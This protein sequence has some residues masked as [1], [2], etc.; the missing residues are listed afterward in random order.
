M[1]PDRGAGPGGVADPIY[2]P[3]THI[4]MGSHSNRLQVAVEVGLGVVAGEEIVE[5]R[6][7]CLQ[8]VQLV[9]K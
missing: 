5:V 7:L 8:L 3:V 4:S 9:E 1:V 2:L 6:I